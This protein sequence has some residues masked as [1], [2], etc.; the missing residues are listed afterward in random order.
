MYF[1]LSIA[2]FPP[3]LQIAVLAGQLHLFEYWNMAIFSA[4]KFLE[5]LSDGFPT[6]IIFDRIVKGKS[7]RR[8]TV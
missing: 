1:A 7:T 5:C 3:E 6:T 2:R 8:I 4:P